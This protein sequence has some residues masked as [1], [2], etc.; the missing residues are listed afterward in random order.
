MAA[1]EPVKVTTEEFNRRVAGWGS[2]TAVKL[3][4][5]IASMS[6]KGK[7]DLLK[8]LRLNT[9][10]D[11]GEISILTYKFIRH[12]VF[13]HKGVGRGYVMQGGSV[14]RGQ[15]TDAATKA[16]ANAKGRSIGPM[17]LFGSTGLLKRKPQEWFNPIIETNITTLADLI[18]E[19][20]AD[21]AVNATKILIK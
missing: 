16:Y 4:A 15:K 17:T 2:A 1:V 3:R 18:A 5:S 11:Y 14:V 12:G 6:S 19:M 8:S 21:N 20:K 7:G 13:F 9:K 10:K